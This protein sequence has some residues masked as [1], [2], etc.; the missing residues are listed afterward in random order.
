MKE[1]KGTIEG[2]IGT[3]SQRPKQMYVFPEGDQGK[4]CSNTFRVLE[5][6]GYV[7]LVECR[8][9]TGRTHQIRVHF[10]YL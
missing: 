1:M 8:L 2:N 6:L 3:K 5:R 4:A 9:E 10:Q 7:N